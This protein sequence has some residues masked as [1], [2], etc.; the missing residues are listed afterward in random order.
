M[1]GTG[2]IHHGL[3]DSQ[4]GNTRLA[5]IAG[6]YLD[7]YRLDGCTSRDPVVGSAL[8]GA[9][10]AGG[11]PDRIVGTGG[12]YG[13]GVDANTFGMGPATG[14]AGG[15]STSGGAGGGSYIYGGYD[16]SGGAGGYGGAGAA[17]VGYSDSGAR[18]TRTS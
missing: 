15:V 16:R 7:R 9:G 11:G 5:N 8:G 13:E 12:A 18:G 14:G 2:T 6:Y 1:A 17:M 3:D 4:G 10:G